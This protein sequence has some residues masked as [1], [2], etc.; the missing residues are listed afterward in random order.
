MRLQYPHERECA[1]VPACVCEG[2]RS[3]I[4]GAT[5]IIEL[6]L[7]ARADGETLHHALARL[8]RSHL[9]L[10]DTYLGE[11]RASGIP[12]KAMGRLRSLAAAHRRYE[13]GYYSNPDKYQYSTAAAIEAQRFALSRLV[14]PDTWDEVGGNAAEKARKMERTAAYCRRIGRGDI[15]AALI[16]MPR[17]WSCTLQSLAYAAKHT[18]CWTGTTACAPAYFH[19]VLVPYT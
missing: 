19:T 6:Q 10:V 9:E 12:E 16:R 17:R 11:M 4:D 5:I 15:A 1:L 7:S 2:L 13:Q 18:L 8:K 14:Y 3:R